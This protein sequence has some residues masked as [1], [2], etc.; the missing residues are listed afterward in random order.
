M[1]HFILLLG[2]FW[3]QSALAV[4]S[5]DILPPE[6]AF[7]LSTEVLSNDKIKLS[8]QIADGYYLYKNKI[9]VSAL[10]SELI[11]P[12]FPTAE[13]KHDQFFGD[14]EIYQ[15]HLDLELT[16]KQQ[17][18]KTNNINLELFYQGCATVGVCYMPIQKQIVID[19]HSNKNWFERLTE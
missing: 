13:Q 3:L 8:W 10:N 6:Q 7:Q 18:P 12:N 2:L 16:I 4:D 11:L 15:H 14:V 1:Y 5:D 17:N 9:H 19:L